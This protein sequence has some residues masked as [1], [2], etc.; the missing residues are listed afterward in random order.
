MPEVADADRATTSSAL[1]VFY[2]DSGA[3]GRRYRRMDEVGTPFCITVD[4]ETLQDGTV[5][6]RDRD[7][8]Q[9]DRVG[10]GQLKGVVGERT[11]D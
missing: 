3:V 2:D 4:C 8:M 6:V 5:T 9:Q 10:G 1:P 11:E 7:T